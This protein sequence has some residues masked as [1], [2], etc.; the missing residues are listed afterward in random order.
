MDKKHSTSHGCCAWYYHDTRT[1]T[2]VSYGLPPFL[3]L[4][5]LSQDFHDFSCVVFFNRYHNPVRVNPAGEFNRHV[6]RVSAFREESVVEVVKSFWDFNKIAWVV[7]TSVG[8]RFSVVSVCTFYLVS[9]LH[10]SPFLTSSC[11]TRTLVSLGLLSLRGCPKRNLKPPLVYP[12]LQ[13]GGS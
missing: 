2:S 11:F 4:N 1:C 3:L 6:W 9:F 13:N 10:H 5:E 8:T 7:C 12:P